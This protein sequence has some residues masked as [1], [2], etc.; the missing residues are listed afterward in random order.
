MGLWGDVCTVVFYYRSWGLRLCYILVLA[1]PRFRELW[2]NHIIGRPVLN[3]CGLPLNVVSKKVLS[4]LF[5]GSRTVGNLSIAN[6]DAR[7]GKNVSPRLYVIACPACCLVSWIRHNKWRLA[8]NFCLVALF[9]VELLE[10]MAAHFWVFVTPTINRSSCDLVHMP[11]A[12]E[13]RDSLMS[14]WWIGTS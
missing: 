5:L 3:S 2:M 8:M 1:Y 6:F 4:T 14:I 13:R 9:L 11:E 12:C 7:T 10:H